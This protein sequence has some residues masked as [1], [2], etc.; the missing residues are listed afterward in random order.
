M[1][2]CMTGVVGV[3]ALALAGL[4]RLALRDLHEAMDGWEEAL[5]GRREAEQQRDARP[6]VDHHTHEM[7]TEECRRLSL[8]RLVADPDTPIEAVNA[9]AEAL[10]RET[11]AWDNRKAS[12]PS[13]RRAPSRGTG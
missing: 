7:M 9:A 6:A 1:G 12:N 4:L 3:L 10:N 8:A 11:G 13:N 2:W 5:N